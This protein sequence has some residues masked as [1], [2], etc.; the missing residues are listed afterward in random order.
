MIEASRQPGDRAVAVIASICTGDVRCMLAIGNSAVMA[1][2]ASA[3]HLGVINTDH[4]LPQVSAVAIFADGRCLNVRRA[5]AGSF[6]AVM[7]AA[8]VAGDVDVIEVRR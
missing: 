6:N 2:T 4:G 3:D 7:A 5:F 8:T 1:G